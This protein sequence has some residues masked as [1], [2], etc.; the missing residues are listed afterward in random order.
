MGSLDIAFKVC[1]PG[2]HSVAEMPRRRLRAAA[3]CWC[4]LHAHI[5]DPS[6]L[7]VPSRCLVHRAR[8][9]VY[10]RS[11]LWCRKRAKDTYEFVEC[12]QCFGRGVRV[13]GVCFGTGLRNVRGLLRRPEATLMVAKMRNGELRAGECCSRSWLPWK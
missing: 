12:P 3:S 8:G 11:H 5:S 13:C 1:K 2:P 4:F 7:P 9:I 10:L 6:L